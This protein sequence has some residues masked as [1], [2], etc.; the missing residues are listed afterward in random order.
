M[1]LLVNGDSIAVAQMGPDCLFLDAPAEHG[2][3]EATVVLQVDK[4]ERR[5]K[6][7]MPEGISRDSERV[8]IA[9]P[10]EP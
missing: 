3:G 10:K 5:W 1:R 6:V 7:W 2:P 8:A 4:S 9:A